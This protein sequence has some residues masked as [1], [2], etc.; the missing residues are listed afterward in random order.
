MKR[1]SETIEIKKKFKPPLFQ[2]DMPYFS[3]LLRTPS[4][5]IRTSC[6]IFKTRRWVPY[7]KSRVFN[8]LRYSVFRV[9]V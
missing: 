6:G 3:N 5:I 2:E 7:Q 8:L 1:K 9:Y 4:L